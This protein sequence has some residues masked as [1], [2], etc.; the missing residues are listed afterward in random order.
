M[1]GANSNIN[2]VGTDFD[3]IKGNILAYLRD[4]NVLKDADYTGSALS[5]LLDI[6]A[7]NTHYNSYYLNMAVNEMF[8]DT[9]IKRSSVVSHAKLLGYTP[10]SYSCPSSTVSVTVTGLQSSS[11][12]IPKFSRFV[13]EKIDDVNY[14]FI[15]DREYFVNTDMNGDATIEDVIIKEGRSTTYRFAYNSETNPN[16]TFVLPDENIDLGTLQVLVQTSSTNQYI[17]V[18]AL[19]EDSFSLTP[20]TNAYFIDEN[21]DEKFKI[22]FG[23]GILGKALRDGN[24]VIVTYL[25][26]DGTSANKAANFTLIDTPQDDYTSISVDT[27]YIADSG[28]ERESTESIRYLAPKVFSSQGRAVTTN[29]YKALIK[30]NSSAFPIDAINVWDGEENEPPIYGKI[31][32]CLKP[33]G[34]FSLTQAQ[35][36]LLI[37]EVIKPISVMTV[38]PEIVDVDYTFVKFVAT[39]LVDKSKT[40][41]SDQEIKTRITQDIRSYAN[42]NLNSFESTIFI[43]N[44]VSSINN[45]DA[46]ILTNEQKIY[47]QKRVYP[48]FEVSNSYRL[49]FGVPIKKDIFGASVSFE[50]SVRYRD[51][52]L[53]NFIRDEVYLEQTPSNFTSIE[54]I[55]VTNS[56]AN[57]ISQPIITILGDGTGATATADVVNGR[58]VGINVTNPGKNYTQAI[59]RIEGGGGILASAKVI[60]SGQIGTLRTYYYS[61]GV[62]TILNSNIGTVDYLNG[63]VTLYNFSPVGINNA[64][65]TLSVNIIPD[66]TIISSGKNKMLTIDPDE[67]SSIVINIVRK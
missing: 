1:A 43:P 3:Q 41:L 45:L 36:K 51:S 62:K 66:T 18:F 64:S 9:A 67:S 5:T 58:L 56:G 49:D 61:N 47:L 31:F 65:G 29:D 27:K 24:V 54:S 52:A 22:Y 28:T 44:Y 35:K 13:S 15:T 12:V 39:V 30:R 50:S 25:V 57:Y 60:L 26:T 7:Y 59:V 16:S 33:S 46:S 2:L 40:L 48:T 38:S 53:E 63:I 21:Y 42:D 37:E 10:R 17:E 32:V 19:S 34:G 23:N 11:F 4:Q 55:I 14:T 8:L 20:T 6:L